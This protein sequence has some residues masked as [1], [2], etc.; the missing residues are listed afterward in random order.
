MRKV[1]ISTGIILGVAL[2]TS[3]VFAQQLSDWEW[4]IYYDVI[5]EYYTSS[6]PRGEGYLDRVESSIANRHGISLRKLKDIL[7]RG[8]DRE[9]TQRELDISDDL[10][11]QVVALGDDASDSETNMVYQRIADKYGITLYQLYEI[12]FRTFD[13]AM[14]G[15]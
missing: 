9:P 11:D 3:T 15:W 4:G 10:M 7:D 5:E 2:F 14:W 12:D 13:W 6:I 8:L 1:V